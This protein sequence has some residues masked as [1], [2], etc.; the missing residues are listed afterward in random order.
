MKLLFGPVV[1]GDLEYSEVPPFYLSLKIHD[2]VLHNTMLDS[3]AS[4]SLMPKAIMDI[5]VLDITGPYHDLYS[6]DSG[7]VKCLSLIKDLMVS[8]EKI[9]AKNV[10]MDVFV[11]DIP[12]RYGMF[13]SQSWG[14]KLKRYLTA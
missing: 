9:L 4:H 3:R 6:F 11:A 14:A 7:R 13:L 10:L 5:L 12:P 1:D 8:L 2:F